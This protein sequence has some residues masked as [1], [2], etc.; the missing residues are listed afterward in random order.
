MFLLGN[1]LTVADL[2]AA[3]LLKATGKVST[4]T[5]TDSNW[6][7]LLAI[8]NYYKNSWA[9]ESGVDWVSLYVP[10]ISCGTV[11][12]TDTFNLD[13]TINK[14]SQQEGDAVRIN[15]ATGTN[16][17]DFALISPERLKEY[18][19]NNYVAKVGAALKFNRT[20][21]TTDA[22]FG[23]TINVPAYTIPD[24]MVL[25][26]DVVPVDDPG[27][28]VTITAAEFVRTDL[29]R[30]NQY[31]NLVSEANELMKGMIDNNNPQVTTITHG[32]AGYGGRTW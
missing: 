7:K 6:L 19:T 17:S 26:T 24:D 12:A 15:Y 13:P 8:A 10:A 16:F 27:W 29:T 4:L 1:L 22:E 28:L 9:N 30:Q 31:P 20:F 3:S 23:G 2:I 11:T 25:S 32:K 21:K 5:P 18:N 14:I